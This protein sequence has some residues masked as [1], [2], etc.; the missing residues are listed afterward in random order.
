MNIVIAATPAMGPVNPMLGIAWILAD[1]RC[2]AG[3]GR[4]AWPIARRTGDEIDAMAAAKR[5]VQ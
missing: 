4:R 1:R 5:V 3:I 2:A